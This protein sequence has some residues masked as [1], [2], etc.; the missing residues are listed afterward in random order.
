M[1]TSL[2]RRR[3]SAKPAASNPVAFEGLENRRLMSA[4]LATFSPV[5][6]HKI[7]A[8]STTG[9]EVVT[10]HNP[11]TAPVTETVSITLTPSLDG[12]TA[13]GSYGQAP[14]TETLTIN[15]H[16]SA[17]VDVP[18]VAPITLTGGKYHTLV[19]VAFPTTTVTGK[20]PGV[21]TLNIPP[22][23]TTTPSLLGSY[24]GL[25]KGSAQTGDNSSITHEAT[26][27][28]D[29]TAQTINSF[30][31][32]F[33]VGDQTTTGTM[34]GTEYNTGSVSFTLTSA[35]INYTLVGT[36]SSNGLLISGLFKSVLVNNIFPKLNGHVK[37]TRSA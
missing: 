34:T 29:I 8:G 3:K 1:L 14:T 13:A 27:F 16:G 30:T 32:T 23:A 25:I 11:T 4:A 22:M 9:V 26:I 2:F 10:I 33:S 31:G 18:F 7:L 12:V 28:W 6:P 19:T 17:R 21:F 24:Q 36:V 35:D 5:T 37:L 15:K 20:A